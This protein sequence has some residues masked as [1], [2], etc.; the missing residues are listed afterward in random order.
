MIMSHDHS[1]TRKEAFETNLLLYFSE[2]NQ[3][4]L[5]DV[6]FIIGQEKKEFYAIKALFAMHSPVFKY[7]HFG[8]VYHQ[9]HVESKFDHIYIGIHPNISVF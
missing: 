2:E 9:H 7:V 8:C 3:S 5:N 4:D 1:R 6:T